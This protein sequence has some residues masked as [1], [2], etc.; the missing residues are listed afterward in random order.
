[1]D[2]NEN[3]QLAALTAEIVT[4]YVA[5]NSVR[6]EE[7]GTIIGDVHAALQ[8]APGASSAA[9]QGPQE[10]VVSIRKSVTPEYLFCL[11]DGKKF[12]SLRRHLQGAHGMTPAEYREKW[13]L[14]SDYPM[15]APNYSAA[16]SAL[17]KS[18]GLGRKAA[19]EPTP[20]E[21]K[22]ARSRRKVQ[23]NPPAA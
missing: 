21:R 17:A 16:R 6:P 12:K 8:R 13:G 4:S 3:P 10:P 11:E 1:M 20:A 15:T 5:N 7:L 2:A 9:E 23:A 22:P 19:A 18:L 14:K